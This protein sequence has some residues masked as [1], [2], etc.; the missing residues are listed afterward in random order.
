MFLGKAFKIAGLDG[1][2]RRSV[3]KKI[4]TRILY[5]TLQGFCVFASLSCLAELYSSGYGLKDLLEVRYQNCP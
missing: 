5:L 2:K 1:R 3:R 4:F